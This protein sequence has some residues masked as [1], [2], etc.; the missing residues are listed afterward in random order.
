MLIVF[1]PF[2]KG[3]YVEAGGTSGSVEEIRI[4]NTVLKTPDNKVV[5]VP[6]GN[7]IGGNITN[8]SREET[9]R[10]DMVVGVGYNDDL[11][12][13]KAV[14]TEL[15]KADPRILEDPAP[16]IAVL[17][18]GDNS[19]NLA[20]RPWVK[21]A[22]YWGVHFDLTEKIKITFDERGISIPYPQRDVH[23]YQQTVA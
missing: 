10:L 17:E 1:R 22:D 13:V 11:K 7:I 4:F 9:R 23:M 3:E 2:T 15:V 12:Q 14:L 20:V 18:L 5:V 21:T 6:N 16:T 19:V 8:Y